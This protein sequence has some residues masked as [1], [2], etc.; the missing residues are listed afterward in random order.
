[1][2]IQLYTILADLV[3]KFRDRNKSVAT[4]KIFSTNQVGGSEKSA[5]R[6]RSDGTREGNERTEGNGAAR[7][8][9]LFSHSRAFF[10]WIKKGRILFHFKVLDSHGNRVTWV[11][12]SL[13][14]T[15]GKWSNHGEMRSATPDVTIVHDGW[16][17]PP[18]LPSSLSLTPSPSFN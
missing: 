1:M 8:Q 15:D 16:L 12:P 5:T 3:L 11:S 18:S 4:L 10:A 7:R 14:V 6:P 2:P 13:G 17:N 9:P